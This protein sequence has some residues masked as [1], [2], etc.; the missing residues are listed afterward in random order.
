MSEPIYIAQTA[1][2]MSE[3]RQRGWYR[4]RR[5]EGRA[6]GATF[7]RCSY[8]LA[9][10]DLLLVEGWERKPPK[11]GDLRWQVTA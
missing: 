2:P 10:H 9:N 8:H 5:I 4:A 11:Q 6:K 7:F 3:L 1:E